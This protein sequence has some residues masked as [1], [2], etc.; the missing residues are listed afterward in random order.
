MRRVIDAAGPN[1]AVVPVNGGPHVLV[2]AFTGY[3]RSR[4][5]RKLV[6]YPMFALRLLKRCFH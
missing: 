5:R 1:V 6:D 2:E 4:Y 3:L